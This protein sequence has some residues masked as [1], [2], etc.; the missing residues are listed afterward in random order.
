MISSIDHQQ[1]SSILLPALAA[2]TSAN[3]SNNQTTLP[4]GV[5]NM[6][7][8]LLST[9]DTVDPQQQTKFV[10]NV[11]TDQNSQSVQLMFQLPSS[12]QE[13]PQFQQIKHQQKNQV[14]TDFESLSSFVLNN[15]KAI[16][17]CSLTKK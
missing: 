10:F 8:D 17:G 16:I 6:N 5:S 14:C 7:P 9:T 11:E 15:T 1:A 13:Q 4:T 3:I 2:T 12:M